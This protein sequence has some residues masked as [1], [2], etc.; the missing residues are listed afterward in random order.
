LPGILSRQVKA[1][2]QNEH[3]ADNGESAGTGIHGISPGTEEW[4]H[5]GS[6]E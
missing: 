4:K 1:I 6:S 5:E 3:Q 2:A